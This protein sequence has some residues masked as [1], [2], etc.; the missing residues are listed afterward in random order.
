MGYVVGNIRCT[1]VGE[2]IGWFCFYGLLLRPH[3]AL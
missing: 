3:F 1:N 2:V